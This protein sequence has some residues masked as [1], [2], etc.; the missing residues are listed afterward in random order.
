MRRVV[1]IFSPSSDEGEDEGA[2]S[3]ARALAGSVEEYI[4]RTV[5]GG[6][7]RVSLMDI[8]LED[9]GRL[10]RLREPLIESTGQRVRVSQLHVNVV[11]GETGV[12]PVLGS[13]VARRAT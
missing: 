5:A 4:L 12:A 8:L 3:P 10:D 2:A 7:E 1:G 11:A 9:G 6:G 13:L